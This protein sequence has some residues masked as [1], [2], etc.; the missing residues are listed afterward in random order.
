MANRGDVMGYE[1]FSR[2]YDDLYK[3][4]TGSRVFLDETLPER[5]QGYDVLE[6]GCGTG[7]NLEYVKKKCNF[8]CGIDQSP[9][10]LAIAGKKLPDAELVI[11]DMADF[12]LERTFDAVLV[13]FDTMNHLQHIEEWTSLFEC[14]V[15]HLRD[16]GKLLIDINTPLRLQ[17]YGVLPP[18][19]NRISDGSL[20][21]MQV[22]ETAPDRFLFKVEIFE[23]LGNEHFSRIKEEIKEFTPDPSWVF[24]ELKKRFEQVSIYN[25]I[26]E[27][28]E[29][30]EAYEVGLN[31]RLY[32]AAEKPRLHEVTGRS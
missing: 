15:S 7:T 6:L 19:I 10:M 29:N 8:L 13:L 32:Y 3:L 4:N 12:R 9:E 26:I 27:P 2:F 24:S 1:K 31:G 18:V 22:N 21:I 23:H 16:E 17:R 30:E 14:A 25:E 28:I 11:G 5:E 20:M